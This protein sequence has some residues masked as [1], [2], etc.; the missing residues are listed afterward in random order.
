MTK[1]ISNLRNAIAIAICL[2]ASATLFAQN[3]DVY[4]GGSDNGK[5]TVWKNGTPTVLST[6]SGGVYSVVVDKGDVYAAGYENI[7]GS[8][9][10]KLW[11]NGVAL[12]TI[13]ES[14]SSVYAY[15][16]ALAVVD[17]SAN[18]Y[19]AGTIGSTKGV[20]WKDGI[21]MGGYTDAKIL[22]CVFT[23]VNGTTTEVYAAGKT[24]DNKAAVWKNGNRIYTL[25]SESDNNNAAWS[26]V[27]VGNDVYT[28]GYEAVGS[29]YISRVWRN[30]NVHYTLG[31]TNSPGNI[32]LYISNG[33][34]YAA[35][36]ENIS[37]KYVAKVWKNGSG[38]NLRD[39]TEDSWALSVFVSG[40]DVYAAG[41]VTSKA[42]L[43][44]N[45][46]ETIL[47]N[48]NGDALSVFVVENGTGVE[49]LTMENGELR[50]YPNPTRG[51][52][53]IENGEL[54]ITRIE[55]VDLSGKVIYQFNGVKNQINVS[56]LSSGIYFLQLETD[57]GC[58]TKKFIKE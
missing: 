33:D 42:S 53:I 37:G 8:T 3:V 9:A 10:A 27:V 34:I 48:N 31:G 29:N 6:N 30:N 5:A 17:G 4:V 14:G 19:M 49:E 43:W 12:Y 1:V 38:T 13:P 47:S 11:R 22:Y 55:I 54:R 32:S 44:K 24:T 18:V 25:T 56:A 15:S 39:G 46:E 21:A 40:S 36:N 35:G 20:I 50:I 41:L 26:V 51:E 23:V 2:A 58:V 16:V 45:G 7:P 57:K 52:L 28:A